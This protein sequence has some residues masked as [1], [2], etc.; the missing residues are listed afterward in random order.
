M[1][2]DGW[3]DNFAKCTNELLHCNYNV[4]GCMGTREY[5]YMSRP[6]PCFERVLPLVGAIDQTVNNC[7]DDDDDNC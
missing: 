1:K 5:I 3:T 2:R 4:L 7:N 6:L